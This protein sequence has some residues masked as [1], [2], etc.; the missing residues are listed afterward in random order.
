MIPSICKGLTSDLNNQLGSLSEIGNA[1]N[2]TNTDLNNQLGGLTDAI[3]SDVGDITSGVDQL[4][5]AISSGIPDIPNIEDIENMLK[6]CDILGKIKNP[7]DIIDSFLSNSLT[8]ISDLISNTLGSLFDLIEFPSI[9]LI[10]DLNDLLSKFSLGDMISQL[11]G[12]LNCLDSVCG[13]DVSGQVDS[14]NSMLDTYNIDDTGTLDM[15]ALL[16]KATNV[17][18]SIVSNISSTSNSLASQKSS[19]LDSI[20]EATDA[21]TS[22]LDTLVELDKTSSGIDK[23]FG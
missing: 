3:P 23:L 6:E 20:Y 10:N 13:V 8:T 12:L 16:S 9:G 7:M 4:G 19:A 22:G 17:P 2:K 14:M 21:L 1:L 5:D 18:S 11:D 15:N